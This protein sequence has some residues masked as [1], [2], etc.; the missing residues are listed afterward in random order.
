[1]S[2]QEMMKISLWIRR[3]TTK[4]RHKGLAGNDLEANDSI[5]EFEKLIQIMTVAALLEDWLLKN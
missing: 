3:T 1:M 5:D 2:I 4:L